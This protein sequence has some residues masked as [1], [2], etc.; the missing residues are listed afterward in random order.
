MCWKAIRKEEK[1]YIESI[2]KKIGNK[3]FVIK[4]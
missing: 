1:E 2:E 3:S 4:E